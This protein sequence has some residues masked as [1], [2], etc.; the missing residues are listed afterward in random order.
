MEPQRRTQFQFRLPLRCPLE[1][2]NFT[3]QRAFDQPAHEL[4]SLLGS[5]FDQ[6]ES[7]ST[8]RK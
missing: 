6:L 3:Q 7:G 5:G 1:H 8:H 2:V 4:A